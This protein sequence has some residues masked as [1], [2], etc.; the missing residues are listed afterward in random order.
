MLFE[1]I[2]AASGF[3]TDMEGNWSGA[4]QYRDYQSDKLVEIPVSV[5]NELHGSLVISKLAFTDPGQIVHRVSVLSYDGDTGSVFEAYIRDGG[6]E[7]F[8]S[9]YTIEEAGDGWVITST[10]EGRDGDSPALVRDVTTF[11]GNQLVTERTVDPVDDNQDGFL[12][13]NRIVLT[14]E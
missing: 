7:R 4:L 8:E 2:A 13:R 14:R 9:S 1:T 6:A 10:R 11:S 3:L 12:F 5:E